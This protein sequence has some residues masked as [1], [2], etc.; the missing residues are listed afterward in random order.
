MSETPVQEP[1]L[2][3]RE[4]GIFRE[5]VAKDLTTIHRYTGFTLLYSLPPDEFLKTRERLG[6]PKRTAHDLYNYGC[7]A[8]HDEQNDQAIKLFD[9]ALK[10]QPNFPEALYNKA[11]CLERL[12]K[13]KDAVKVWEQYLAAAP[14]DAA[15]RKEVEEHL[16]GLKS[17]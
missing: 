16:A 7:V 10:Q 14:A 13:P 15:G 1:S 4:L 12:S 9:Q 6:M 17:A 2:Y 5:Q 8:A 11:I 3:D